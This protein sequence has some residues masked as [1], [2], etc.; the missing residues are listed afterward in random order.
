MFMGYGLALI[1]AGMAFWAGF[2]VLLCVA[3]VWIG[4][5]LCT[6]GV[7]AAG[8]AF[9]PALSETVDIASGACDGADADKAAWDLDRVADAAPAPQRGARHLG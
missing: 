5:A 7:A 3:V 8:V 6:L 1:I 4:G 2:G 9:W